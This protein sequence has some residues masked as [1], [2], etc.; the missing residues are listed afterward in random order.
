MKQINIMTNFSTM[1]LVT[2][3][4]TNYMFLIDSKLIKQTVLMN[5]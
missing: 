3:E 5:N 2:N 1:Y 4:T